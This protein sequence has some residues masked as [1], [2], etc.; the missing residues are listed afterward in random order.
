MQ[1]NKGGDS[2]NRCGARRHR[3]KYQVENPGLHS[4]IIY[5]QFKLVPLVFH[6]FNFLGQGCK[7]II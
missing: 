1:E 6:I 5:W 4:S 7:M 2:N 3:I